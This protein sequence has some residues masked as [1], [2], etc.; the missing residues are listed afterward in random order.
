MAEV[1][2]GLYIIVIPRNLP[3]IQKIYQRQKVHISKNLLKILN[4]KR[5][6]KIDILV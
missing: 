1:V 6:F 3:K 4:K 5:D 2:R